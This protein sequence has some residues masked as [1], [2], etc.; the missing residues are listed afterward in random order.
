M[1]RYILYM[2]ACI[3]RDT[4]GYFL[5]KYR[6]VSEFRGTSNFRFITLWEL[7]SAPC[8]NTHLCAKCFI[9]VSIS[10]YIFHRSYSYHFPTTV[11]NETL[12]TGFPEDF[13]FLEKCHIRDMCVLYFFD[14]T[15]WLLFFR[16]TFL[17]SYYSCVVFIS[18]ESPPKPITA[19]SSDTVMTLDAVSSKCSLSVLL[20]A[21]EMSHTTWTALVLAHWP[22]SEIICIRVCVCHV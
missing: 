2:K 17:C 10:V 8:T 15:L 4:F 12:W 6:M 22:L 1:F 18:L 5:C 9:F 14:Q 21:M 3:V 11:Y 13:S 19:C 7:N 20:W 16:C